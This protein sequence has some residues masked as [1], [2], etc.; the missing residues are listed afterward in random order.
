MTVVTIIE[1]C[2]PN[3]ERLEGA[4]LGNFVFYLVVE[5]QL[6]TTIQTELSKKDLSIQ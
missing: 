4:F 2:M 6:L 1:V 5:I 3:Q